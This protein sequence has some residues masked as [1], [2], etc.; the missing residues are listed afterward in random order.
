M[1]CQ[2]LNFVVEAICLFCMIES[3][4]FRPCHSGKEPLSAFQMLTSSKKT[5]SVVDKAGDRN[6]PKMS[7]VSQV[8]VCA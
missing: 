5:S 1:N 3:T 2:I 8:P 6:G 7:L 4:T